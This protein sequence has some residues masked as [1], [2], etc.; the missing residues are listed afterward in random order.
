MLADILVHSREPALQ[1]TDQARC[2]D[3]LWG[4]RDESS[5]STAT[6]ECCEGT[7]SPGTGRARFSSDRSPGA[8][9]IRFRPRAQPKVRLPPASSNR[10]I[11]MFVFPDL[12]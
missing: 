5:E 11:H 2:F 12:S 4:R 8:I 9:D 10:P 6:N 3:R 1:L 7:V